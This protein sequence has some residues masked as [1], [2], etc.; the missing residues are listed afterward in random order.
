[1][2]FVW[3]LLDFRESS[4]KLEWAKNNAIFILGLEKTVIRPPFITSIISTTKIVNI[5]NCGA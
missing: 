3:R 2:D 1:M 4:W 5:F